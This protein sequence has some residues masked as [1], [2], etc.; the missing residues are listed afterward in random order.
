MPPQTPRSLAV[1]PSTVRGTSLEP[2]GK[3]VRV[4][5]QGHQRL[6]V[7]GSGQLPAAVPED[8]PSASGVRTAGSPPWI[9]VRRTS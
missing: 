7:P 1:S 2:V 6:R 5:A 4:P 9:V 3:I 8:G